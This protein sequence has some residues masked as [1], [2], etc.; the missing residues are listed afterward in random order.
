MFRFGRAAITPV[1][2]P[3]VPSEPITVELPWPSP[4]LSPNSSGIHWAEKGR[5]VK[6]A[7][8]LAFVTFHNAVNKNES[9]PMWKVARYSVLCILAK[10]RRVP[11]DDNLLASLKAYRDGMQDAGIVSNDRRLHLEGDVV[12]KRD[13]SL[14]QSKIILTVWESDE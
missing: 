6:E 7:R 8:Q 10:G 4:G 9:R 5:Q 12:F 3:P 2:R 11:D 14:S 1:I 13:K